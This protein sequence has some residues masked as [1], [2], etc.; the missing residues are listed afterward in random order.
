M[1]FDLTNDKEKKQHGTVKKNQKA[2]MQFALSFSN[3]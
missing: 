3:A 1:M 2:I